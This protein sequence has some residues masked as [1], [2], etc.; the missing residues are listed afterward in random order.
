MNSVERFIRE[1]TDEEFRAFIDFRNAYIQNLYWELRGRGVHPKQ[2]QFIMEDANIGLVNGFLL[3]RF[4]G[5]TQLDDD[6]DRANRFIN[7]FMFD[8]H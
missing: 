2:A 7:H 6:R 5:N 4:Q 8:S 1:A 3:G